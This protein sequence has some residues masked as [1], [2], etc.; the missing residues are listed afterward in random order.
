M[1][2]NSGNKFVVV[3]VV[4]VVVIDDEMLCSLRKRKTDHFG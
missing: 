2:A 1:H 3:V 4:V